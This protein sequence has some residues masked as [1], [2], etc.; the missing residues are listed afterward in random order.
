MEYVIVKRLFEILAP[1]FILTGTIGN[2]LTIAVLVQHKNRFSR[3][4]V[5]LTSLAVS[6]LVALWTGLLRQ[7][8]LYT[9]NFDVRHTYLAV[10]KLHIFVVYLSSQ[11]S[12][13]FMVALTIE[14]C[15]SVMVPHR[16]KHLCRYQV[17]VISC[18][19]IIIFLVIVNSHWF[20]TLQLLEGKICSFNALFYHDLWY[21]VDFFVF[22][23]F[24]VV[25]LI[26]GN[27]CIIMRMRK[28]RNQIN[29]ISASL[30]TRHHSQSSD[31]LGV[32][33]AV[34][35][36]TSAKC[37]QMTILLIT[38]SVFFVVCNLPFSILTTAIHAG[39]LSLDDGVHNTLWLVINLLVYLNNT[40][41]FVL[42]F[43]SGSRFRNDVKQLFCGPRV[44][45]RL[46]LVP[47]WH[48][49]A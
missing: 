8:V 20:W 44:P 37:S 25:V 31:R 5:F 30:E 32:V 35:S 11:S 36:R 40:L 15:I 3:S 24:P 13:W 21:I 14:R 43:L 10:C 26:F 28:S 27:I 38:L 29:P 41:N 23:M 22:S 39:K 49:R 12:S 46:Q 45:S 6:D 33:P 34:K 17:T 19:L 48:T 4:A 47:P 42:Y 7:W 16:V 18:L 1:V 2:I 9:F